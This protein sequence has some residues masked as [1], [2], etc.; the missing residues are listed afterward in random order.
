MANSCSLG[1]F[2]ITYSIIRTSYFRGVHVNHTKEE[3]LDQYEMCIQI[4]DWIQGSFICGVNSWNWWIFRFLQH[5]RLRRRV[6]LVVC[7]Y[8]WRRWHCFGFS[9]DHDLTCSRATRQRLEGNLWRM[10]LL[11]ACL[12]SCS[13]YAFTNAISDRQCKLLEF[14][15]VYVLTT[16]SSVFIINTVQWS[17]NKK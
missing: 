9:F 7:I 8:G 15:D 17:P 4:Y 2:P 1:S 11:F 12:V 3:K 5:N 16:S 13:F 6:R 14:Q 10:F